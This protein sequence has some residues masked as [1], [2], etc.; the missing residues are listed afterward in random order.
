MAL[1]RPAILAVRARR[2]R[3]RCGEPLH[4]PALLPFPIFLI[5]LCSIPS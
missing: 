2:L 1:I 4:Q 3:L 5:F